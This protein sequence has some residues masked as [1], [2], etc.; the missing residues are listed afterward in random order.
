MTDTTI[1]NRSLQFEIEAAKTLMANIRALVGEDDEA[2]LRDTFEGE[3]TLDDA[4]RR[5]LIAEDEDQ[6]L[7][8][9]IKSREAELYERR[10]RAEKRIEQRRGLIEQAMTLAQKDKWV[11]PIG[12]ISLGKPG[13]KVDVTDESKIPSAYWKPQDPALDRKALGEALKAID[14]AIASAHALPAPLQRTDALISVVSTMFTQTPELTSA[15]ERMRI[16][17]DPDLRLELAE[18]IVRGFEPIS[19]ANLVPSN[20]SVSIR[21]K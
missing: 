12:T 2:T 11:L 6:I 8:D 20:R 1:N 21:R 10:K 18:N 3:T 4:L 5:C 15:L 19:G 7:I 9:G 16:A 13:K 17:N 14:Q